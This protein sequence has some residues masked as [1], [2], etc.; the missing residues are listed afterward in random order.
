MAVR[1][2]SLQWFLIARTQMLRAALACARASTPETSKDAINELETAALMFA[3]AQRVLNPNDKRNA[4]E[5]S[6][7]QS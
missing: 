2:S 7:V 1:K 6:E 5:I 4:Q 3:N